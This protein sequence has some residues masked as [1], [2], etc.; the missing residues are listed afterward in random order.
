MLRG[1]R[2]SVEKSKRKADA[3]YADDN[4]VRTRI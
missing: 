4:E 2:L 3:N 1:I